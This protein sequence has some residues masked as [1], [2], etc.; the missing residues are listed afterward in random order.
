MKVVLKKKEDKKKVWLLAV[1]GVVVVLMLPPPHPTSAA[2]TE[3]PASN[4]ATRLVFADRV[5][6]GTQFR[7]RSLATR[8]QLS[9]SPV[10]SSCIMLLG[11]KGWDLSRCR[12]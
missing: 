6:G 3:H 8:I 11:L 4:R 7:F 10:T 2:A 5:E 1:L 9:L 12:W